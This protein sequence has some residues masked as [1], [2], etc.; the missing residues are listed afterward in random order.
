MLLYISLFPLFIKIP[1]HKV[2]K[3]FIFLWSMLINRESLKTCFKRTVDECLEIGINSLP[4]IIIISIFM[5]VV[6]TVQTASNLN[7][8]FMPKYIVG[9]AVRNMTV[10]E[11]SPTVLAIVIAGKIGSSIA[12]QLS[13]MR[14]SEQ[15]DAL[16]IFGINA[17][18]YLVMPKIIASIITYPMLVVLSMFLAIYSGYFANTYIAK[19]SPDEYIRGIT[20]LF[21]P[22]DLNIAL[23][24][25]IVFAFLISSISSFIGFYTH[26]G[27]IEV[28]N[29]STKAVTTSCVA[30][31]IADYLVAQLLITL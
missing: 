9:L 12:S 28:G 17:A 27:S 30:I 8:P 23:C 14:I 2:G 10:L 25:S 18:S 5:G 22:S 19:I 7:N 3:Y 1:M 13:S 26:G 11:L 6:V 21:K 15:I 31:L 16:E 29:A 20:F 24:K 4:I